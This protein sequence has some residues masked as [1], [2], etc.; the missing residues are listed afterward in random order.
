MKE[1]MADI[2]K[3]Y[4]ASKEKLSKVIEKQEN[5]AK[6]MMDEGY[7]PANNPLQE[8]IIE[9]LQ[10]IDDSATQLLCTDDQDELDQYSV[11]ESVL[12][13]LSCL[14]NIR[15]KLGLPPSSFSK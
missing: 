6:R 11:N 8:S 2:I 4:L 13:I 15:M 9:L 10:S 12:H 3:E 7:S 14:S 5:Y 1:S